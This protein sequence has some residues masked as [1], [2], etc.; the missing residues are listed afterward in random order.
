MSWESWGPGRHFG[1]WWG[2]GIQRGYGLTSKYFSLFNVV[3]WAHQR[4]ACCDVVPELYRGEFSNAAIM[5]ALGNLRRWG[6]AAAPCFMKPEGVVVFH[7][8]AQ[9]GF[10]KTLENDE[11]PKGD[12]S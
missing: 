10:K 1:E 6:S 12:V 3:R 8:A 5:A 11:K 7:V 9:I 4:P 2:G